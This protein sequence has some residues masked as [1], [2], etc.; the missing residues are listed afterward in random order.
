MGA[1]KRCDGQEVKQVRGTNANVRCTRKARVERVV[2]GEKP[3]TFNFCLKC[4]AV[5]DEQQAIIKSFT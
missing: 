5:W 2:P 1:K 3:A 4:A